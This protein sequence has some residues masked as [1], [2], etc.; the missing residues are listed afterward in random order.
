[1][2]VLGIRY[3]SKQNLIISISRNIHIFYPFKKLFPYLTSEDNF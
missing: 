2:Y 1:M 3:I